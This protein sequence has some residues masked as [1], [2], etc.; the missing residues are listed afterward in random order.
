[1][2]KV[3][4]EAEEAERRHQELGEAERVRL[5]EVERQR[6]KEETRQQAKEERRVE[7]QCMAEQQ[8]E[9]LVAQWQQAA[10]EAP[11]SQA[12][13]SRAAVRQPDQEPRIVCPEGSY[14]RCIARQLLCLWKPDRCT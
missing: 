7:E 6:I 2:E 1:M 4:R 10:L 8:V 3:Q 12:G 14:T 5:E 11:S 9:A 13:P